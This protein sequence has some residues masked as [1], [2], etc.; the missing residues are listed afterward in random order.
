MEFDVV[1][2]LE[3]HVELHTDTKLFCGCSSKFG[4]EPN[5]QTCPV[6]LA[7]PGALPVMNRIAFNYALKAA[8][9]LNCKINNLT[10]FDRKGYYYPDLPKN[11]QIS[12]NYNNLG[13]DGFIDLIMEGKNKRVTLHNVHLEEDAGKLVHPEESNADYSFVDFNRAGIPLLEIVS[14]PDIQS[15]GEAEAYMQTLRSILHY[16]NISDC[17]MQ[18]GSL[19]FEAS[20]SLKETGVT[21]LGN[22][23]EIKNLNSVRSV[24]K[25]IEYEINRQSNVLSQGGVI[26]R[27]TRL[28]DDKNQKSERMRSK[29]ESQ[30]YRYFP[31]PDLVPVIIE[32]SLIDDELATIPELPISRLKRFMESDKLPFYDANILIQDLFIADYF[33]ECT[34]DY[35]KPKAI[36]NWIINEVLRYL[37]ENKINIV[38]FD[39]TP[40]ML[41]ELVKLVEDGVI[42]KAA[43]KSVFVEMVQR[44]TNANVIVEEKGLVQISNTDELELIVADIIKE[45]EK[46]VTD[47]KNGKN[48]AIGFLVGKIMQKTKGKANPKVVNEMLE[49]MIKQ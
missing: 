43:A 3:T 45:N 41:I 40:K 5:T 47:F 27:E 46:V 29:E 48:N 39:I 21:E 44:G 9:A 15:V 22:R 23:V 4:S 1:I 12:Q 35:H 13:T 10:H 33:D 14:N 20:I 42:S 25:S 37:N 30:D 34:K 16:I 32:K 6:C 28:W 31:E 18:E 8:L 26:Y 11:F 7:L 17:K 38:G 24:I 2:G 49:N 36:S 19:R